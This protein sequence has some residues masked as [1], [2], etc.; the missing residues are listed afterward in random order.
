MLD[1]NSGN[2]SDEGWTVVNVS[3]VVGVTASMHAA[4]DLELAAGLE[5]GPQQGSLHVARRKGYSHSR[6]DLPLS[7][8]SAIDPTLMPSR[9]R[10]ASL[11]VGMPTTMPRGRHSKSTYIS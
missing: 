7:L 5:T 3:A 9:N 11:I 1:Q 4:L 10:H 8:Q 6:S 2:R